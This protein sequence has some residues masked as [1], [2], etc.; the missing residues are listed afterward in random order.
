MPLTPFQAEVM[1]SIAAN[2]LPESHLAGGVV[3]NRDAS[4]PRYSDDFDIFHDL[5]EVVAKCAAKDE[6]SLLR[7]GYELRWEVRGGAFHRAIASKGE[8]A[9]RLEWVHDSAFR[10][11]PVQPDPLFGYCLHR[12]DAA[13]NKVLAMA[14]RTKPRD[15]VDVLHLDETYL[16]VGALV[17]AAAGKDG[18]LT[19]LSILGYMQRHSRYTEHDFIGQHLRSPADLPA[20]KARWLEAVEKANS[21]IARLPDEDIGC[22]YLDAH[23]LPVTPDPDA[24]GFAGLV[25]HF[26][27]VRG[28]WPTISETPKQET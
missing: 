15:Y 14:D 24:A 12:A 11:F 27:C 19:P 21:L 1:K 18:G 26:G 9:L 8:S 25:K 20:M 22:L 16:S 17:W 28:A 4:S 2:R 7:D 6:A 3:L 13:T 5:E 10:F 23:G